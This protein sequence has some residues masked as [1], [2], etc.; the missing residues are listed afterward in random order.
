MG[1]AITLS[2]EN[3]A[4]YFYFT[5]VAQHISA[6]LTPVKD[7]KQPLQTADTSTE[8]VVPQAP[9]YQSTAPNDDGTEHS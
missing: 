7:G 3:I 4:H 1:E 6:A 5:G 9:A 8:F 2:N